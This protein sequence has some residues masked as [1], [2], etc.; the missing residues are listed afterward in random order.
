[1]SDGAAAGRPERRA[2]L[3][4]FALTRLVDNGGMTTVSAAKAIAVIAFGPVIRRTIRAFATSGYSMVMLDLAP[5]IR[6]V[7]GGNYPGK[8]GSAAAD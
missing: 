5:S 4:A 7:R 8:G 3:S 6:S 1:M 2:G